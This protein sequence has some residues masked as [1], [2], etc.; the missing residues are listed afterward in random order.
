V[1]QTTAPGL[2]QVESAA[3]RIMR[4]VVP[5]RQPAFRSAMP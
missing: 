3:Q 5:P 2:P 1:Q 4:T